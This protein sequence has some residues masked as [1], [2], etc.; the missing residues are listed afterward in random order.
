VVRKSQSIIDDLVRC[1]PYGGSEQILLDA[2]RSIEFL[3]GICHL[4]TGG[5]PK[6][7]YGSSMYYSSFLQSYNPYHELLVRKKLLYQAPNDVDGRQLENELRQLFGYPK[8]GEK[9]ITETILLKIVQMLFEGIP[10]I[11]HYRGTEL[12]GLEIDIWVPKLKIAI[13]YQGEQH[14][15]VI[16]HW[17]GEEGLKQRIAN[18]KKKKRLCK[19]MGYQLIEFRYDENITEELVLKKL[20]RFKK[21]ST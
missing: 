18:D 7:K 4:C 21:E 5:V 6:L 15:Q 3:D 1:L 12:Q 20:R 19:Q 16:K 13:E 2:V 11:H 17:G 9:W 8:I 14:Y 10:V